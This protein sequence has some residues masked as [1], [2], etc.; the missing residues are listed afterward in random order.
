LFIAKNYVGLEFELLETIFASALAPLDKV[1][2]N[3]S[4]YYSTAG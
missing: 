2:N 1:E 3:K 4:G